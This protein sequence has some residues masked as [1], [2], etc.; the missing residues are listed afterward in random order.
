M[1]SPI[2]ATT[3][4]TG[5]SVTDEAHAPAAVRNGSASVKKA[6]ASAQGFEEMLM[7]QLSQEM[8]Q[9]SGLGS[10]GGSEGEEGSGAG[11]SG[12]EGGM[13]ASLLP[14]ALTEGVMREGGLGLATQLMSSLDPAAAAAGGASAA[15]AGT[16]G[17]TT[18]LQ[19]ASGGAAAT[20]AGTS[21]GAGA[22]TGIG[23]GAGAAVAGASVQAS[24][25]VV[26]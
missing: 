4:A 7:Q 17:G 23:G 14:Q 13:L 11:G 20:G 24:G 26:A 22:G 15:G 21:A 18:A 6:Y 3:A 8:L 16:T 2:A 1:S 19:S 9:S 25:G 5:L 12:G 10:E